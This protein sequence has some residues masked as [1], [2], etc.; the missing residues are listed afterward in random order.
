LGEDTRINI[1]YIYSGQTIH[2]TML[3]M[4]RKPNKLHIHIYFVFFVCLLY[5][6]ER[7]A[8]SFS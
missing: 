3:R 8:L 4:S 5:G 2:W 6:A 1:I 7:D